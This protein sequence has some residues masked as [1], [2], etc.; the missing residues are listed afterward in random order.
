MFLITSRPSPV[1]CNELGST[2]VQVFDAETEELI[3]QIPAEEVLEIARYLR[4]RLEAAS[5]ATGAAIKGLL[6]DREG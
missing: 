3:R 4:G 6:V 5:E 1:P 2:V